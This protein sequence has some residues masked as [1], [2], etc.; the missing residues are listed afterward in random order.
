MRFELLFDDLDAQLDAELAAGA[1]HERAEEA[2]L[3][4]ARS[5]LRDRLDALAAT[6]T[7]VRVRLAGGVTLELVPAEVGRDWLAA[8][9]PNGLEAIVPLASVIGVT[10]GAG[11][12]RASRERMPAAH[13]GGELATKLGIGVVLR[14]LARR[15][16]PVDVIGPLEGSPLHGTIDRVGADHFDLAVHER[17][18]ARRETSVREYGIVA[19]GAVAML[20]V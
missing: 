15:R 19:L 4:A 3:R 7:A 2:R 6:A 20:R 18:A 1:A 12:L 9:L 5:T 17:G 10:L 8:E 13:R 14:N 11:E 16:V